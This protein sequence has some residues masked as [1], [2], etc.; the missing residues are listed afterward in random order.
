MKHLQS[1]LP[2]TT[3]ALPAADNDG[4]QLKRYAILANGRNFDERIAAAASVKAIARLPKA[5]V[6]HDETDNHGVGFQ[7]IHFAEVAVV[8]PVFYW[9]WGSVLANIEQ[10]RAPWGQPSD[11]GDGKAEVVGCVWE[12]DI[13]NFETAAWKSTVLVN[14]GSPTERVARYMGQHYAA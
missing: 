12:M 2:R 1:F 14:E 3:L 5:G 4:W 7:I 6:I 11:F 10:M 9:Q 13:V 8:S